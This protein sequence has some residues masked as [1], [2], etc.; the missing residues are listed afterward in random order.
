MSNCAKILMNCYAHTIHGERFAGLNICGLSLIKVFT[1]IISHCFGHS[2][3]Y[4]VQ[5]KRSA[6]IHGKT[7][8]LLLKT[9][10]NAKVWLSKTF[11]IYGMWLNNTLVTK[12][13]ATKP[14]SH[15][16]CD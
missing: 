1:K 4:L 15:T 2:A 9:M 10:K 14:E 3:H 7:F 8:V 12:G 5:L 11:P 16:L 6:Y 13:H